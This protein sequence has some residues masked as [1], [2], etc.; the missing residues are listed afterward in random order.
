MYT[1][2]L[3]SVCCLFEQCAWVVRLCGV[4]PEMHG[5]ANSQLLFA[6]YLLILDEGHD[7]EW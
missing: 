2:C 6:F 5:S 4:V 7:G 3:L 1:A